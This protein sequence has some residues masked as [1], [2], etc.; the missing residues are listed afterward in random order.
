M[1]GITDIK[2]TLTARASEARAVIRRAPF[3]WLLIGFG[4]VMA[5]ALVLEGGVAYEWWAML[6]RDETGSLSGVGFAMALFFGAI[7]A[8]VLGA[9]LHLVYLHI[10]PRSK[11]LFY[12]AL[13]A[14]AVIVIMAGP[15]AVTLSQ[16]GMSGNTIAPTGEQNLVDSLLYWT[17]LSRALLFLLAAIVAAIGIGMIHEGLKGLGTVRQAKAESLEHEKALDALTL[18]EEEAKNLPARLDQFQG[19]LKRDFVI[20][21]RD[22]LTGE[23]SRV[24][25]YLAGE[26]LEPVNS[27]NLDDA[28]RELV[29]PEDRGGNAFLKKLIDASSPKPINFRA[30]PA[31]SRDLPD[32]ARHMLSEHASWLRTRGDINNTMEE[33]T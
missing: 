7:T 17:T 18:A 14:L 16:P 23:A 9:V 12:L 33:L 2:T 20:V 15:I 19:A 4:T 24:E 13:A 26:R 30:L 29:R 6:W 31:R 10:P 11:G 1:P 5:L 25:Q 27:F 32:E 8:M 3:Y 28:L 21:Y 22:A